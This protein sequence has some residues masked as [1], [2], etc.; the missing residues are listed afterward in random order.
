M[1][2]LSVLSIIGGLMG[3]GGIVAGLTVRLVGKKLDRA[4]ERREEREQAQIEE[5]MLLH[6]GLTCVGHV[7]RATATAFVREHGQCVEIT[8]AVQ[9]HEQFRQKEDMQLRQRAAERVHGSV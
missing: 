6:E 4:E 9:Y 7:A 5:M 1:N 8:T 2:A 3:F